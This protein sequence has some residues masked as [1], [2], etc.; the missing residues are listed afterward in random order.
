YARHKHVDLSASRRSP[1]THPKNE[2]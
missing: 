1:L 2:G